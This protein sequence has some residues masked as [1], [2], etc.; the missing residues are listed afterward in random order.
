MPCSSIDS[1][2]NQQ[3]KAD[4]WNLKAYGSITTMHAEARVGTH[5]HYHHHAC[6]ALSLF[7]DGQYMQVSGNKKV[8]DRV[9][10]KD[11]RESLA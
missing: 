3:R 5:T 6:M 2:I 7:S 4:S 11:I 10:T 1:K 9:L 8:I